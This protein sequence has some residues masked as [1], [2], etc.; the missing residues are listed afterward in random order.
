LNVAQRKMPSVATRLMP[1]AAKPRIS[2]T[3][4]VTSA[5]RL[6][7]SAARA[8][9]NAQRRLMPTLAHQLRTESKFSQS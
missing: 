3:R 1:S 7:Q 8:R 9:K 4:L 5:L 2:V 6:M